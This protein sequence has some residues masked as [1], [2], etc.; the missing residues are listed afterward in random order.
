[1]KLKITGYS[2]DSDPETNFQSI[3][4]K[5]I[6]LSAD[7]KALRGLAEFFRQAAEEIETNAK[8]F[9]SMKFPEGNTHLPEFIVFNIDE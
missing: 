5:E 9:D 1:M 4:L 7:A 6:I 2:A 8:H 3:D